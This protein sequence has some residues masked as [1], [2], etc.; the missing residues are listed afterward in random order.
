MMQSS[1]AMKGRQ[2]LN[3]LLNEIRPLL[4]HGRVDKAVEHLENLDSSMVKDASAVERLVGYLNRNKPTIP[5]YE[6]RKSLGLRNSSNTVEK[7]N[8]LVVSDRQKNNGMSWSRNGSRSP[9]HR[10]RL[11]PLEQWVNL[12]PAQISSWA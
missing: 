5:C 1:L 9:V 4:W 3:D 11:L 6:I 2:I 10:S 12:S 8:D 7:M